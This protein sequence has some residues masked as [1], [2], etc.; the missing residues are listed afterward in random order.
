MTTTPTASPEL[1]DLDHLEALARAATPGRWMR[2]FGER[3]VYDRMEDGC[4]GNAIVRADLG[5]GLQ[6]ISNLDF[7]AAANPA[8]VLEL[9][10][11]ARRAALA[12]QPAPT[13]P[14]SKLCDD[15]DAIADELEAEAMNYEGDFADTVKGC[16]EAL[17]HL[18]HQ[19][20]QEQAD[21]LPPLTMSVYG[22]KTVL[23][24]ERQRRADI[25]SRAA[26][27]EPVAAPQTAAAR[28]V[29]AERQRQMEQEGCSPA[30]DDK[31]DS[32]EL[33][34]A[35]GCYLLAGNGPHSGAPESWPW[36]AFWWKPGSDRRNMVKAGALILADIERLDR[37][38]QL[39]GGQEGSESNA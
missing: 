24:L 15:I 26:Q 11:L 35:A 12:N 9:I 29:L 17:R 38:A 30:Q 3:T 6:D 23:E 32:H 10:A 5:Y 31:Y 4:R 33:S 13:V 16:A 21:D 22:T 28:D 37:A 7:I 8:A 14:A 18:A 2:L 20:A 34:L 25:A 39:D 36:E 1:P 27:Q 19:P